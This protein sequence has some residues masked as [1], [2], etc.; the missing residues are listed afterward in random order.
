MMHAAPPGRAPVPSGPGDVLRHFHPGAFPGCAWALSRPDGTHLS[1]FLGEACLEPERIPVMEGTLFDL[2]SL[3]KPLCTALLALRAWGDGELDLHAPVRGPRSRAFSMMDLL[4]HE[5]GF[6]AWVPL[7]GL[8]LPP[9]EIQGWLL[10]ACP[11][12]EPRSK[13]EYSCLDYI[14][15]GFLLEDSLGEGLSRLFETRVAHRLGLTP[16]EALFCPPDESRRGIAATELRGE[17]EAAK[18]RASGTSPGDIPEPGLWGVVNDGNARFLG[19][20]A[21]NAGLFA[22]SRAALALARAYLPETGWLAGNALEAA[23][24]PGSAAAGSIFSAGWKR[25]GAPGW[26]SGAVLSAGSVGHEGYTGTGVWLDRASDSALVLLTNR[27]HPRHPM[28]DFS[29][30]RAA[31]LGAALGLDMGGRGAYGSLTGVP[32][33]RPGDAP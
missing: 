9:G 32:D 27:I 21:G 17:S 11:R 6:P 8:G 31:F 16:V 1:G 13:A 18:A 3:T 14:L 19:G 22:T 15:L 10:E 20:V 26:A 33:G 7:Y 23:W 25:A 28:T 30:V 24:A 4:R 5:A 2:A 29:P 12:S